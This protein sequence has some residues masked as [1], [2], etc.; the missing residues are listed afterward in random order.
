MHAQGE[1]HRE[2]IWCGWVAQPQLQKH[3]VPTDSH[4]S[5]NEQKPI[6]TVLTKVMLLP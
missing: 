5:S 2:K 3:L 6:R 4:Q 1:V